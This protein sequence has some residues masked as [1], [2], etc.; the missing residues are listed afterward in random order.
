MT[1]SNWTNAP[2]PVLI[3]ARVRL[4]TTQRLL[5]KEAYYKIKNAKVPASTT[6]TGGVTVATAYGPDMQ[7]EK[8]LGMSQLVFSDVINSRDSISLNILL[9]MQSVLGVEVIS[10]QE[11]LDASASYVDYVFG[12]YD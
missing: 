9:K 1:D 4:S 8:D 5:L 2:L 12:K 7:L 11:I 6:G 3:S 10:K